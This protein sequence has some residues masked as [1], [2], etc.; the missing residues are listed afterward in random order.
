M[1]N[2]SPLMGMIAPVPVVEGG[3]AGVVVGDPPGASRAAGD[4]P[5][6]LQ[7]AI[8]QVGAMPAMSETRLVC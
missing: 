6:I 5:G 7:V 4:S 8:C 2:P 3:S 1:T